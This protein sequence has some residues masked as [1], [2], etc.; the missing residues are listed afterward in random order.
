M[1]HSTHRIVFFHD[2]SKF[3]VALHKSLRLDEPIIN[4]F[5]I[6]PADETIN[7]LFTSASCKT[8]GDIL[9]LCSTEH[10][11][12]FRAM[13]TETKNDETKLMKQNSLVM[14]DETTKLDEMDLYPVFSVQCSEL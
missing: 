4:A 6:Y 8:L 5:R 10:A 2:R 11:Q 14:D 1:I 7:R 3:S 13:L 12:I 9:T